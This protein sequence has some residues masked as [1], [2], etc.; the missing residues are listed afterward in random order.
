MVLSGSNFLLLVLV[1]CFNGR[2]C[3]FLVVPGDKFQFLYFMALG[4]LQQ[5]LVVIGSSCWFICVCGGILLLYVDSWGL[6]KVLHGFFVIVDGSW[7][8]LIILGVFYGSRRFLRSLFLWWLL[9]VLGYSRWFLDV[10]VGSYLFLLVFQQSLEF[11][12]IPENF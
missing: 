1:F 11:I 2:S 7:W 10:F 6:F 3:L 8:F 4:G 9:V 5:F 12:E